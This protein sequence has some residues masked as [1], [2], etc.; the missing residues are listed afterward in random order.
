MYGMFGVCRGPVWPVIW[1]A[2]HGGGD[3]ADIGMR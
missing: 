2:V 3:E 1:V